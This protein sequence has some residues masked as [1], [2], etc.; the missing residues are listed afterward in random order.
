MGSVNCYIRI[1]AT[2]DYG[3]LGF[4]TLKLKLSSY[5]DIVVRAECLKQPVKVVPD[6]D[7][8][9]FDT[10]VSCEYKQGSL[11]AELEKQEI[12]S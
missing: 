4:T 10:W 7:H 1:K 6:F 12:V 3:L 9:C 5:K 2:I 8:W 11:A